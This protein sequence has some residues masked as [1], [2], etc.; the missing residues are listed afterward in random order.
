V[1]HVLKSSALILNIFTVRFYSVALHLS[2]CRF[3]DIDVEFVLGVRNLTACGIIEFRYRRRGIYWHV[4]ILR[5]DGLLSTGLILQS[6]FRIIVLRLGN[7]IADN[8][9]SS[10]ICYRSYVVDA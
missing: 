3:S 6:I 7:I 1:C 9:G 2:Y 10:D 8:F 4:D 5:R